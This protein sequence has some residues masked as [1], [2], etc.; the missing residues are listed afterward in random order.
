MLGKKHPRSFTFS[1][2]FSSRRRP[3]GSASEQE[4][5]EGQVY[6]LSGEEGQ[7]DIPI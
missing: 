7:Q 1:L 6:G 3:V 5:E 2:N 4:P